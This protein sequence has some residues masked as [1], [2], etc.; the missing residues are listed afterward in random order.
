MKPYILVNEEPNVNI[1][2][3]ERIVASFHSQGMKDATGRN[4]KD[5][6]YELENEKMRCFMNKEELADNAEFLLNR[7]ITEKGFAKQMITEI[8]NVSDKIYMLCK[9]ILARQDISEQERKDFIKQI[10]NL[11]TDICIYGMIAPIVEMEFGGITKELEKVLEKIPDVK[12]RNEYIALLSYRYEE[13]YDQKAEKDL[14]RIA[15]KDYTDTDL[16]VF[17]EEWG[18]IWFG[19]QGPEYTIE[20][21][22]AAVEGISN[23]KEHIN[24][25]DTALQRNQQK[26]EKVLQELD[27]TED[28]QHVVNVA[29]WIVYGK[30]LRAKMMALMD[31]TLTKLLKY[32]AIREGLSMKQ[33]GV[34]TATEI[35]AYLDSGQFPDV[36]ELNQ[37]LKYALLISR[38]DGDTILTGDEGRKWVE[39]H[40][41]I[42]EVD[43][44]VSEIVGQVACPGPLIS[45]TVKIVNLHTEMDKFNEGDILVSIATTPDIVPVM[46][47]AAA[48]V[49]NMGGLTC[50]A[51]IVSR[52]L[53]V[54]CIIGTKIATKVLKNGDYV[55]VDATNGIVKKLN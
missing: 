17:V 9:D 44:N 50:H 47:K 43:T 33:V 4:F 11:F 49:T 31:F 53:N 27:L 46:K 14:A 10:F 42:E 30:Y 26:K 51:A 25:I 6:V 54:P 8:E 12:T 55:E 13:S 36:D 29:E 28:E 19:Y 41:H 34:C 20:N 35:V 24:H 15:E 16:Q 45:G 32:F 1:L 40:A 7:L 23:P 18:W 2:G 38:A 3:V 22:R 37:R 5:F 52:E 21:A 48:I 39:D